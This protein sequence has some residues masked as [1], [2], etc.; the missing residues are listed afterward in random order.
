M[1]THVH[2]LPHHHHHPGAGHPPA[3]IAPSLM[4][5][6]VTGRLAAAAALILMIWSA[7]LWAMM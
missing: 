5:L 1:P 4:R 3:R 2:D 6:P 7:V